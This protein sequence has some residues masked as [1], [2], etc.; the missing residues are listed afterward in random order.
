MKSD[1]EYMLPLFLYLYIHYTKRF[2][3]SDIDFKILHFSFMDIVFLYRNVLLS[4]LFY[5]IFPECFG[6]TF[7]FFFSNIEMF[8]YHFILPNWPSMFWVVLFYLFL[9]QLN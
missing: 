7:F 3:V 9:V 8:Y 5:Q 6:W 4:F 1:R 2:I